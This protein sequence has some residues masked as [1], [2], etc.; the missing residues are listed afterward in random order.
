MFILIEQ[1]SAFWQ[2][3]IQVFIGF[4]SCPELAQVI[5]I[6]N[7]INWL[8]IVIK[9]NVSFLRCMNWIK[10]IIKTSFML[11]RI[12]LYIIASHESIISLYEKPNYQLA[13]LVVVI[14]LT[15]IPSNTIALHRIQWKM[16]YCRNFYLLSLLPAVYISIVLCM[17]YRMIHRVGRLSLSLRQ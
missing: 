17:Y 14:S 11:H 2:Q 10:N 3:S 15:F 16:S 5:S 4:V 9:G 7:S 6:L 8:I 13:E 1:N 12:K